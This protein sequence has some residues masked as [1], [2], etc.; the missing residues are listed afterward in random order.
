MSKKKQETTEKIKK[1]EDKLSMALRKNLQRRKAGK[2]IKNKKESEMGELFIGYMS[3]TSCDGVDASLVRT[4]GESAFTIIANIHIPYS[5]EFKFDLK[6]LCSELSSSLEIE[7]KLTEF[8]IEATTQLLKQTKYSNKDIRA[9]GFHGQTIFH[10][11]ESQLTWQIGNP[12]LLAQGTEIDVVHDFR[13]RDISLGGQGAPLVP[14]FHKLLMQNQELPVAVINIGGV[15]NITYISEE[16]GIPFPSLN[17]TNGFQSE[18]AQRI[19]IREHR[20][21]SQNSI[22][23]FKLE[24]GIIA[25]DTGPGNALIDDAMNKYFNKSYDKNGEIASLGKIDESVV[26]EFL[27]DEYFNRPYPKSL[28][29][30]S[31]KYI[32]GMFANHSPEDIIATLTYITCSTIV[33]AVEILP[34][35]PISIFLCGGGSRNKQIVKWLES[36]LLTKG[37][38][39]KIENISTIGNFNQ[40]YI[41]SQA[42]AYLAA[43]FFKDLPSAFPTTTAAIRENICGCLVKR[44]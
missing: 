28:D 29:R 15:A 21:D 5:S 4:D 40:D 27:A 20:R 16:N 22:G 2:S 44:S 8:H 19:L 33:R 17:Q 38:N 41:E 12:H 14:I 30:N 24:N 31:F 11:P 6:K 34:N 39:C 9:L 35:I 3:G 37:F 13:R 7:K 42:F 23:S 18:T 10:K 26:S 43:R 25:F 36:A 32:N 1:K